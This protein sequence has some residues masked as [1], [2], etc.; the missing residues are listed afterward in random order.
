MD[1]S[2]FIFMGLEWYPDDGWIIPPFSGQISD[3]K[4]Y[5]RGSQDMKSVSIQYY[6]ALKRIKE[7]NITLLRNVYMTLMPDEEVGAVA[8]M[9]KF[10]QSKEFKAMNVGFELDEG[11]AVN[12][13]VLPVLYQDKAVWQIIVEC[14]GTAGHGSSFQPTNSTAVGKCYNVATNMF[15]YRDEQYQIFLSS[16]AND[17]SLYTSVNLNILSGGSA[18]NVVPNLVRL[19]YDIRLNTRVK[20]SDFQ[21]QLENLIYSAGDNITITY[22]SRNPQSPATIANSSNPYWTAISDAAKDILQVQNN[23]LARQVDNMEMHSQRKILLFHGLPESSEEDATAVAVMAVA[24]RSQLQICQESHFID[25]LA[26]LN[27]KN[28]HAV[29]VSE[30]WLKPSRPSSSYTLP[31]VHLIRND[32][33]GSRGGGIAIYLRTHIPFTIISSSTQPPPANAGENP[34]IEICPNC[35]ATA[36]RG[37]DNTLIP[38]RMS[39]G[40]EQLKTTQEDNNITIRK[41]MTDAMVIIE[42]D[43]QTIA[44]EELSVITTELLSTPI[45]ST[46]VSNPFKEKSINYPLL[47]TVYVVTASIGLQYL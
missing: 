29:L 3:G 8:G 38:I 10:L 16:P 5:G 19:T 27:H 39:L 12:L 17:S 44:K 9:Q 1:T 43:I 11:G 35:Q 32:R 24:T 41:Q 47:C 7:K 21:Q 26:Y 15:Q 28:L 20:E 31:G 22:I 30:S 23:L 6:E 4:I 18:N 13:P 2:G 34:L 33:T 46:S 37:G 45:S 40:A 25:M 36:R 42:D 14:R